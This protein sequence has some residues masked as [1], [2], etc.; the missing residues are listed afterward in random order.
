MTLFQGLER[1]YLH[2]MCVL[3]LHLFGLGNNP[4]LIRPQKM[5]PSSGSVFNVQIT[6]SRK[7]VPCVGNAVTLAVVIFVF[8]TGDARHNIPPIRCR[9]PINYLSMSQTVHPWH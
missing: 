7:S 9:L 5:S 4:G 2:A 1:R 3:L 6:E 8:M